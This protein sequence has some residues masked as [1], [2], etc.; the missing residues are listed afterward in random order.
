MNSVRRTAAC[1][2]TACTDRRTVCLW[3]RITA[4]QAPGA[5]D[6]QLSRST[7]YS[8]DGPAVAVLVAEVDEKRLLV[9]LGPEPVIR[10]ADLAQVRDGF[11]SGSATKEDH[12]L[13]LGR[14]PAPAWLT[15]TLLCAPWHR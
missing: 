2:G 3:S 7:I 6:R 15:K 5:S 1:C 12:L 14:P 11:T 9:M 13:R 4:N 10:V 8:E